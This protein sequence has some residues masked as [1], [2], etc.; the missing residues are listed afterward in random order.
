MYWKVD[1]DK[2]YDLIL[3]D[4]GDLRLFAHTITGLS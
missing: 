1:Y 2:L 4:L 3:Q